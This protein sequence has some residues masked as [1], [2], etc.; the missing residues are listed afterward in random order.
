[1]NAKAMPNS[2]LVLLVLATL[3]W[4]VLMADLK[5][6]VGVTTFGDRDIF[7]GLRW[8]MAGVFAGALW[9]WIGGLLLVAGTQGLLP[10][11]RSL[12]ASILCP[13]AAVAAIVSIYL[14]SD[15]N[16]RW[17]LIVL[18]APPPILA[19][20]TLLLYRS[21]VVTSQPA[22]VAVWALVLAASISVWPALSQRLAE[23]EQARVESRKAQA[24]WERQEQ[25]RKHAEALAKLQTMSPESDITQWYDLLDPKNGV[26]T[27]AIAAL[28]KVPRRQ[29]DIEEG[30]GYGIPAL[31]RLVPELDLSPRPE[32]CEA[33]RAYLVRM[34][35]SINL[36]K[37]DPY[38]FP[39][40]LSFE[41]LAPSMRWLIS[42]GCTCQDELNQV[43]A[44]VLKYQD[45]P[46]R[47]Q[48]LATLAG[49]KQV[50]AAQ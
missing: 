33:F 30:V 40:A 2:A 11:W 14:V 49:L 19:A 3:T 10:G 36:R 42:H 21:S 4:L 29:T 45:S 32:L 15:A 23:K 24:D 20:Y 13:A 31:L 43:E 5:T 12:A 48:A 18:L 28:K 37:E 34:A 27:E 16:L 50:Q 38:P 26:R 44:M 22:H 39:E 8:I 25:E 7:L 46:Y 6:V 47:Q 1:M 9:L 41:D 17:P 35:K